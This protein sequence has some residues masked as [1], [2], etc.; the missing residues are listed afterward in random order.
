MLR[1]IWSPDMTPEEMMHNLIGGLWKKYWWF[2]L[3]VIF[4]P[5]LSNLHL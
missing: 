5:I 1:E 3:L 2:F 4:W